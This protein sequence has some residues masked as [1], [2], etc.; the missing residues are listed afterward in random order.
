MS[1]AMSRQATA[2]GAVVGRPRVDKG[3]FG[4]GL[5][6]LLVGR[7][8]ADKGWFRAELLRVFVRRVSADKGWLGL[9]VVRASLRQARERLAS[10][11]AGLF[12][13]GRLVETG[14]ALAF[15]ERVVA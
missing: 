2:S 15:C 4:V 1:T 8:S 12:A 9:P 3:W 11:R 13:A 10:G 6:R 7:V 5:S 14:V